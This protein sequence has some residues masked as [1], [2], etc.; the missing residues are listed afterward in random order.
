MTKVQS[1][2]VFYNWARRSIARLESAKTA[3]KTF[4]WASARIWHG[5]VS[6]PEFFFFVQNSTQTWK[7]S[8]GLLF[9]RILE[10]LGLLE[11]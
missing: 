5:G 4:A 1:L 3:A 2:E 11:D 6:R 8:F 7:F 9:A 10:T